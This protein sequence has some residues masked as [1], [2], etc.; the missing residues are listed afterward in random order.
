M[1]VEQS[2]A[3]AAGGGV[4]A[5]HITRVGVLAL[6]GSFREH[7]ALL[8]KIDA[9][10]VVE[11]RTKE[12]L[13]GLS[14]LIIP[15]GESTTMAHIAERWGLIPELQAFAKQGRPIWGTCAGMIFLAERA[16][17]QKKGGQALLGGLDVCV[18][19]NFFGAQVNS[20]ETQL[21]AP[22]ELTRYGGPNTF[23]AMFIRAPAVL[24][25]GGGVEV[26]AEYLLTE[27]E[28]AKA[29]GRG[30]VAVAVRKGQLLA[31]AF[32]P[33]LTSDLRWHQLFVDMARQDAEKR[34]QQEDAERQA[35]Q[36][37]QAAPLRPPTRPADL[38][39]YGQGFLS[40]A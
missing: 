2:S 30:S 21:P 7:M 39:I 13:Q 20:F 36:Q 18:S 16:E 14:G 29:G 28:A 23:R 19:R 32:H 35:K 40:R 15:G 27:A 33:E 6:Q 3:P 9:V 38:P 25:A 22:S 11:V 31:T 1:T 4:A 26:L 5:S 17:G 24:E 10:E 37:Q 8:S 34:Q 12:E